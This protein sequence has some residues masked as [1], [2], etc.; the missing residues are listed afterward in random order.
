MAQIIR[1]REG[2][3]AA[4]LLILFIIAM[5]P[6]VVYIAN[7][8]TTTLGMGTLWLYAVAWGMFAIIVLLWAAKHDAFSLTEEQVPPELRRT[9][10]VDLSTGDS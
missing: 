6:P 10:D 1:N 7:S 4:G 2:K 3:I 9:E 5:N 8:A